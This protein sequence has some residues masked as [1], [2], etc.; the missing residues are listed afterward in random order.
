MAG[1]FC[2]RVPFLVP[3]LVHV[4]LAI[5]QAALIPLNDQVYRAIHAEAARGCDL[6]D[7]TARLI[8]CCVVHSA[9]CENVTHGLEMYRNVLGCIEGRTGGK[10]AATHFAATKQSS[11]SLAVRIHDHGSRLRQYRA[12]STVI[13]MEPLQPPDTSCHER[14]SRLGI[15]H[16]LAGV[17]FPDRTSGVSDVHAVGKNNFQKVLV[18]GLIEARKKVEHLRLI[19]DKEGARDNLLTC[20]RD[21]NMSRSRS[22]WSWKAQT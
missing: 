14:R 16:V 6:Y 22:D 1:I 15:R 18:E 5:C 2:A 13:L 10:R 20:S 3:R 7:A 17:D 8:S 9:W 12:D 19:F 11:H 4:L 21:V